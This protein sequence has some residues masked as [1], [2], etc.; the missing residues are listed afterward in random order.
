[1]L[2]SVSWCYQSSDIDF[3]LILSDLEI[4]YKGRNFGGFGGF[5]KN[6]P[7]IRQIKLINI[8]HHSLN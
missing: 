6:P 2:H 8:F 5:V 4:P 1:M 7:K 3:T